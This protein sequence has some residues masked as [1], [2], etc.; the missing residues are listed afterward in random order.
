MKILVAGGAGFIGSNLCAKPESNGHEV[1]AF[2][3]LSTGSIVDG[4]PVPTKLIIGNIQDGLPSDLEPD[5]IYN[6]ACL[7][8]P[9]AYQKDPIGTIRTCVSGALSLPRIG[10]VDRCT[11]DPC[12]NI[13]SLRLA[14]NIHG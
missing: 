6:L 3:N 10:K 1:T 7:A 11:A 13:G 9:V 14:H 4:R 2:D 5:L 8:S 12:I